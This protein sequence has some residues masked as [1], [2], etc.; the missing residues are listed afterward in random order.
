MNLA[1]KLFT[2]IAWIFLVGLSLYFFYD[3]VISFFYGYESPTMGTSFFNNQFWLVMHMVGGTLTLFIGPLQ[4]WPFIRN[5]AIKFHRWA[6]KVYMFGIALIGISAGRLSFVSSCVPCRLSLFL[7]TVFA[8]LSTFFAWKA[9]KSR[10]I[11]VHRHMMI[12]S[13]V[14]VMAFV[15]VRLDWILSLDFLF[16]ATKDDLL[17]R[18]LNEYFFSFVPQLFFVFQSVS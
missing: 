11:K 9:I 14:C 10:N 13:Y 4:F 17:R 1:K 3:N 12:R 2:I 8:V 6:G 15:A 5:R 18:V 16:G 7:L